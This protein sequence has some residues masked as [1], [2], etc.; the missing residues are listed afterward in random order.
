VHREPAPRRRD[1][2][3]AQIAV[4]PVLEEEL[5]AGPGSGFVTARVG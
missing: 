5:V 3:S 4:A 1:V 2:G